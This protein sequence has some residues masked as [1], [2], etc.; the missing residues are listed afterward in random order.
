MM[1]CRYP[2]AFYLARDAAHLALLIVGRHRGCCQD[3][4]HYHR[5]IRLWALAHD[6]ELKDAKTDTGDKP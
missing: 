4:N 3:D 2:T 5:I 1:T 6:L